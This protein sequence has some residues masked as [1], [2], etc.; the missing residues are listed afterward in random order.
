[1]AK[2]TLPSPPWAI[3]CPVDAICG[4]PHALS[5]PLTLTGAAQSLTCQLH[6]GPPAPGS[7]IWAHQ[8]QA[9]LGHTVGLVGTGGEAPARGWGG[10][11]QGAIGH[12]GGAAGI[13]QAS[14]SRRQEMDIGGSPSTWQ[15]STSGRSHTKASS[16]PATGPVGTASEAWAH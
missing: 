11:M 14:P 8:H 6:L 2:S 16:E 13:G 9:V 7:C 4:Y 12:Q 10:Q 3:L 5:S 1:M 15:G